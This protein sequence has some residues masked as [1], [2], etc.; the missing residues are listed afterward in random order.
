VVRVVKVKTSSG[1]LVRPVQRLF[2]LEVSSEESLP[3]APTVKKIAIK[4]KKKVQD[5]QEQIDVV[6]EP[7][8]QTRSG[9]RVKK[10]ARF[11]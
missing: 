11:Q 1:V 8:V 7:G 9:R 4:R 10:P 5:E 3:I 2:P 6:D